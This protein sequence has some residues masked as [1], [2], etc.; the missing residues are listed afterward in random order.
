MLLANK[1]SY[2]S[3]DWLSNQTQ[4]LYRAR[5]G[6]MLC[7]FVHVSTV[8]HAIFRYLPREPPSW[9]LRLIVNVLPA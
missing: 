1:V 7:W 6:E 2:V 8:T 4:T 3:A 5:C 9:Q